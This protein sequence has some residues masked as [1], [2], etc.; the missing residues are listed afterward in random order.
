[1]NLDNIFNLNLFWAYWK[2]I[3][4]YSLEIMWV[5]LWFKKMAKLEPYTLKD[6][7][8]S[9]HVFT[10]LWLSYIF[11][12]KEEHFDNDKMLFLKWKNDGNLY[13]DL[14]VS[15]SAKT[16]WILENLHK[17]NKNTK[18][19]NYIIW[20]LLWYP[21]CC[22]KSF[23][24]LDYNWDLELNLKI[25]EKTIWKLD[26]RLNNLINPYSLIPF[27]PCN[28]NCKNA[29]KYA[30]NNLKIIWKRKKIQDIFKNIIIYNW[31]WDATIIDEY[32]NDVDKKYLIDFKN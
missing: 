16:L 31:F 25:K 19:E 14:Y 3:H 22:I 10:D 32:T 11:F 17:I 30:E 27:F 24:E 21:E 7:E 5:I 28:Y 6:L 4:I 1:M 12:E 18:S 15:K 8:N 23:L 2:F 29:I 13:I 20:K 9:K 26:W